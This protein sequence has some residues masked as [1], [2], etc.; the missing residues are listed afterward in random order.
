MTEA[1]LRYVGVKPGSVTWDAIR[2]VEVKGYPMAAAVRSYGIPV[3]RLEP[4]LLKYR[5][6]VAMRRAEAAEIQTVAQL[7]GAA[8]FESWWLNRDHK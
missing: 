7:M 4:A 2:Y 1:V 5:E 6:A 3:V 8:E